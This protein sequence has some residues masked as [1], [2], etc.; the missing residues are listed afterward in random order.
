VACGLAWILKKPEPVAQAMAFIVTLGSNKQTKIQLVSIV[1][2]LTRNTLFV[3]EV[4]E[5]NKE[6]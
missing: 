1:T 4:W 2:S 3:N 6:K 5:E